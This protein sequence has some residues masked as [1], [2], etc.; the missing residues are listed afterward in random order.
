[1][2]YQRSNRS[3]PERFFMVVRNSYSTA[4]MSNGQW[5]GWDI[6]TDQDGYSI[7]KISGAIRNSVAGCVAQ[8]I[9]IGDYGLIQ[10]WGYKRDARCTGGSGSLTSKLTIGAPMYFATSGFSPRALQRTI[11]TTVLKTLT[12][13]CNPIGICIA[14]LNT[15]GK[16]TSAA[17]SAQYKVLVRCL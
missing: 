15:A 11:A 4:A 13:F 17:T 16:S 2:E 12:G 6:V 8:P 14:P 5:V 1:M 10:V 7:T 3:D 9:A